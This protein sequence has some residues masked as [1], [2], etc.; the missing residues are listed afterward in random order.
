M[1]YCLFD[2][3]S[4]HRSGCGFTD[5][6][7]A[8]QTNL[9]KIYNATSHIYSENFNLNYVCVPKAMLWAHKVLA[10]PTSQT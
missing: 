10:L 3:I 5:V 7:L 6:L 8:L 4:C 9:T 2:T 1:Y